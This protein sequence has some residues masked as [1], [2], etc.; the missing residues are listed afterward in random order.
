M[1][2]A[3]FDSHKYAKRLIDA[4][5]TPQAAGVHAEV[6]LE[7]MSQIAGGSMSGERMEARLGTRMDQMAADANA[8]FGAVDARFDKVD[9]KIDQ[10]ASEL[11]AQIA[12]A[13]ADMVRMMVGL[14]VLQLALISA[15]LLKLTH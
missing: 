13:K 11:H 12:D 2:A 1:N 9:A 3:I 6:L 7:V 15:L 8:R 4:G 14:S 5:V 10:L